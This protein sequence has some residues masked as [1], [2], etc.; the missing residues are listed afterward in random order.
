M[1][2]YVLVERIH[3]ILVLDI[4]FNQHLI[5]WNCSLC[6]TNSEFAEDN[7][8]QINDILSVWPPNIWLPAPPPLSLPI[9]SNRLCT[10]VKLT[11]MLFWPWVLP[12]VGSPS[13]LSNRR[14]MP[15]SV[16]IGFGP[17]MKMGSSRRFKQYPTTYMWVSSWLPFTM[18]YGLSWF[19]LIHSKGKPTWNSP[20]I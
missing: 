10:I 14:R 8:W 1:K 5:I 20:H 9:L 18:D 15:N 7:L 11:C 13:Q 4:I 6:L 3:K 19:I 16:R 2:V 17:A 12:V